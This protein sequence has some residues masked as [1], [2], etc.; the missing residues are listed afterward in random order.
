MLKAVG[1][2]FFDMLI[3]E[4]FLRGLFN[5]IL[6]GSASLKTSPPGGKECGPEQH[7]LQNYKGA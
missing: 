5:G 6:H 7:C 4:I 1:A 3:L 2:V